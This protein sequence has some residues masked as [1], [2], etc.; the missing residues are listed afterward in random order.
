MKSPAPE[1][2]RLRRPKGSGQ[3]PVIP[4]R[5]PPEI[6]EAIDKLAAKA[7]ISRSTYIRQLIEAGL[8]RRPKG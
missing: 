3:Y 6:V 4:V 5:L 7:K 8:K 1:R 2:V